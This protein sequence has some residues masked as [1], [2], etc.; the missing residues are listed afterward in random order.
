MTKQHTNIQRSSQSTI[1]LSHRTH[2]I[3][4]LL[5]FCISE[6]ISGLCCFSTF[7]IHAHACLTRDCLSSLQQYCNQ[8][9]YIFPCNTFFER[10]QDTKIYEFLNIHMEKLIHWP[11]GEYPFKPEDEYMSRSPFWHTY[12]RLIDPSVYLC[13]SAISFTLLDETMSVVRKSFS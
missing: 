4:S 3:Y 9:V 11:S 8:T 2:A 6:F 13:N 7:Q 1:G 12:V 5:S 10:K